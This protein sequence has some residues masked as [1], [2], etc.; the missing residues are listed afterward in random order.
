MSLYTNVLK[1]A[2]STIWHYKYLWWFGV[3]AILFG[4]SVEIELL[5]GFLSKS[6]TSFYTL[7]KFLSGGL[8]NASLVQTIKGVFT[9]HGYSLAVTIAVFIAFLLIM[10]IILC[11]SVMGQM[12]VIDHSAQIKK[13][14]QKP[15]I[16]ASLAKNWDYL[17]SVI[18][19]NLLIKIVVFLIFLIISLPIALSVGSANTLAD[20][21]YLL[22]FIIL[23]PVAIIF[24]FIVKYIISY[25]VVYGQGLWQAIRNSL[26]LFKEN[27]LVSI[28][29]SFML[30]IINI[31]ASLLVIIL[32]YAL[33]IPVWFLAIMGAT[34]INPIIFPIVLLLGFTIF[35]IIFIL[36]GGLIS[37]YT[38]SAWTYLFLQLNEQGGS[39]KITR[40]VDRANY[41]K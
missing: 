38:I 32:I 18:G 5:E 4:S 22:L 20:S 37:A 8:F 33:G 25:I 16:K 21:L 2:W 39:A 17:L 30:L 12:I 34:V 9:F 1:Q 35:L 29:M 40:L 15:S 26:R 14:N 28:E 31:V 23:L 3:L 13:N 24:A 27:W 11:S 19:L 6:E 10:L 41:K 36:G 7:N